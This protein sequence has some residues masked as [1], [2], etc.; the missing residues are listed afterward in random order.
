VK[1]Q[2]FTLAAL[3]AV[4]LL[5]L[6]A[7]GSDKKSSSGATNAENPTDV[8]GRGSMVGVWTGDEQK[9]F[10]AVLNGFKAKYPNVNVTYRSTGDNTPTV[11]STAVQGGNPPDLA[12]VSQPGL[13]ND[14]QKKGSLK[15][16]NFARDTVLANYPEDIEKL[17]EINGNLYGLIIKAANKSTVWYNVKSYNDAG[18]K[19]ADDWETF[20][21]NGETIHAS[22]VPAYSIGGADGWTLTD[23]FENIYLRQAGPDKYDQLTKHQI[24][25]T[26]PS[27]K[28]ALSTM[29]E[30]LGD[31][32]NM[33][34]GTSG[35][36]QTDFPTSVSNVFS[37][38]PKG[39]QVIEG[40]FVPGVVAS[41]N[42][43]KPTTGY[44]VFAFPSVDGSGATVVGG[45][46][47]L[48]MF[49]DTPA[50]RALVSYLATGEAQSIWAKLGG[51]SAPA[52]TVPASAYPDAIT[53]TTATAIGKA[54]TF[55]FDL[56]DLQ[57]AS[58]GGTV[59]QGEFK[60]FQDFLKSPSNVNGI[61][62]SLES[63]A[64]KAYAA[65]K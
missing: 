17:G 1:R 15:P 25:W 53:R 61:A 29:A 59:G 32:E 27:V 33:V 63:A 60:I 64:A 50:I 62:Q 31:S 8:A 16:M 13:V 39:A 3:L 24:K 38:S 41:S 9:H 26:D 49:R 11:L 42:S 4:A 34:G 52:K 28:K 2:T 7:C 48:M 57:P 5:A 47:E 20:R 21:D 35:A 36:L 12:A 22:G 6:T 54:K 18:V 14:F 44:N 55:R 43:L 58:F 30:V 19:P 23:L 65:G 37:T 45:G 46:D 56:S 51:Y 40:D 10:Q